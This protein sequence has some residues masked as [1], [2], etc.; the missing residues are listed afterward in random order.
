VLSAGIGGIA[1][2]GLK[3]N[4]YFSYFSS[5][6]LAGPTSIKAAEIVKTNKTVMEKIILVFILALLDR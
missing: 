3:I 4:L 1:G 5:S 6:E 2:K